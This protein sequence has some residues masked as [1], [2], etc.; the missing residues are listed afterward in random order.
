MPHDV[1]MPQL[2]MAQD[3][4]RIVAWL[5]APGEAVARGD[6]LFE[7]ETDKATM[8]VEAQCDGY[9]AAVC[10]A[11]GED[12]PVGQVI[13]RIADTPE[14][15]G[16][17][18]EAR[19]GPPSR[20]AG[21]E[22]DDENSLPDGTTVTMPQLGM[23]QDDGVLVSWQKAP[24]EALAA[25]DILFEV[26][27]DKTT[28][29]VPAGRSGFLAATLAEPGETVPVGATVA[30]IS[31]T[32]PASPVA[33]SAARTPHPAARAPE[34]PA[35]GPGPAGTTDA[36]P[37]PARN[38]PPK[39]TARGAAGTAPVP[40]GAR[41]LASP[42]ARSLALEEG[43]DLSRLAE[44]GHPQPFH[45]ADLETLRSLAAPS[46]TAA[47]QPADASRRL[48]AE[49]AADGFAP[50]A[51][52]ASDNAGLDDRDALLAGLAAASLPIGG[53]GAIVIAVERF[54]ETRAFEAPPGRQLS[55]VAATDAAPSLLLRD[56][57]GTA[58]TTVALG[59]EEL[60]V[61]SIA[62]KGAGLSI[63]LE[64]A[65]SQLDGTAA[66]R[67]LTEFAGRMEHPLRH[68]L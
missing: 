45:A 33:R 56:L 17:G 24:G 8:E 53:A 64:C 29:E 67:L 10:A 55:A 63:T 47:G 27:T 4:G 38:V 7:V 11:E 9:L 57:R 6:A 31:E 32:A 18:G 14:D 35:P 49:I 2:G 13:A 36:G 37:V 22:G 54:G 48:T 21:G 28:M 30:I 52:W 12:V 43:L 23:A 62:T 58:L 1:T 16:P 25:D 26:E 66:I 51:D 65:P 34:P 42:K 44:A 5:K 46:A 50:F 61:L 60:P 41:V 68:L 40:P 59:A 15:A 3:A 39:A 20:A 19:D